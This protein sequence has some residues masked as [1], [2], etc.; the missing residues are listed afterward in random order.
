MKI[1]LMGTEDECRAVVDRLPTIV[2]VLEVSEPRANRGISQLVRVYVEVRV[3]E[4]SP[5]PVPAAE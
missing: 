4:S 3:I 1:R 2:D 5:T